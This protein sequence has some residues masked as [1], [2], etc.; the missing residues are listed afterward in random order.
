[1][2]LY[3][4][5]S[6]SLYNLS[7][8]CALVSSFSWDS[9]SL[10]L[11]FREV[12]TSV[13]SSNLVPTPSL[14]PQSERSVESSAAVE[15]SLDDF[16]SSLWSSEASTFFTTLTP[17]KHSDFISSP[18][19]GVILF[20]SHGCYRISSREGLSA[21]F[22]LNSFQTRSL[23]SLDSVCSLSTHAK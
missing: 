9:M 19:L 5:Y 21:L 22:G 13:T 12:R 15:A 20:L 6:C 10:V 7:S 2:S 8:H 14:G 4:V 3:R 11:S 23:N 1:M 18:W 17:F 16:A